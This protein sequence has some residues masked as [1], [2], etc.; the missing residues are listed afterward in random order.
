MRSRAGS[1]VHLQG[2]GIKQLCAYG[3]EMTRTYR[4]HRLGGCLTVAREG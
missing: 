3:D 1:R 2:V 4:Q